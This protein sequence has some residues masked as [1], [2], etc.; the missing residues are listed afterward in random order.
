MWGITSTNGDGGLMQATLEAVDGSRFGR[1]FVKVVPMGDCSGVK[2]ISVCSCWCQDTFQ[3]ILVVASSAWIRW[4]ERCGRQ[5]HKTMDN[6][7]HGG[8]PLILPTM[9]KGRPL[10]LRHHHWHAA[11]L[12]VGQEQELLYCAETWSLWKPTEKKLEASHQR[13]LRNIRHISRQDL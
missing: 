13:W 10:Q 4:D 7:E 6:L 5:C 11:V 3:L 8:K 12:S 1:F 2:R 9:F